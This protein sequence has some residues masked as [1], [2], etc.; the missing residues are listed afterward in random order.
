MARGPYATR[1]AFKSALLTCVPS[2][3]PVVLFILV[4]KQHLNTVGF[5]TQTFCWA[6]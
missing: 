1:Y 4:T 6:C 5:E 2:V 3:F